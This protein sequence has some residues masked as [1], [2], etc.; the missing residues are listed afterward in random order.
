MVD[1]MHQPCLERDER[2]VR[3][4]EERIRSSV[5]MCIELLVPHQWRGCHPASHYVLGYALPQTTPNGM[6]SSGSR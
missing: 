4:S 6:G 1:E 2:V 5:V 3:R